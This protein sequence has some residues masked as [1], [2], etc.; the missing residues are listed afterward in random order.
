MS[1][2]SRLLAKRNISS[3]DE[4]SPE[5]QKIYEEYRFILA[6]DERLTVDLIKEFCQTQIKLIENQCNGKESLTMIQQGCLHV[7]LNLVKLIEAP[8]EEKK[9]LEAYLTQL[10]EK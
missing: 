2:L 5:E 7:Y 4:L 8:Q 3:P 9:V 10:I 6:I 1:I